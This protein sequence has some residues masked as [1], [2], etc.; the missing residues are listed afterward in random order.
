MVRKRKTLKLGLLG[1]RRKNNKIDKNYGREET[2]E[3]DDTVYDD[4][5]KVGGFPCQNPD[6]R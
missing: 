6:T 4:G 3:E 1:S 5:T 2:G